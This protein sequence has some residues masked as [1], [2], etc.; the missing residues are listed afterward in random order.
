MPIINA[1]R[2]VV[3]VGP[4]RCTLDLYEMHDDLLED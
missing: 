3:I 2:K 4:V 1:M